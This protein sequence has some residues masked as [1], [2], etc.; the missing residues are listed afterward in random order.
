M[1]LARLN[2]NTIVIHQICWR[3]FL[4]IQTIRTLENIS[5]NATMHC[6]WLPS[7]LW[8][9]MTDNS[10]PH[11]KFRDKFI[12]ELGHFKH[13]LINNIIVYRYVSDMWQQAWKEFMPTRIHTLLSGIP[14]EMLHENKCYMRCLKYALDADTS[15]CLSVKID[16]ISRT[17]RTLSVK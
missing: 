5:G 13:Y 6:W 9:F 10:S 7:M 1:V 16:S 17:R 11:L 3:I 14:R 12:R 8:S 2:W 4:W 15:R